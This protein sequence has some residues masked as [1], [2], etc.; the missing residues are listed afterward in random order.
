MRAFLRSEDFRG[1]L[2]IL[3][4]PVL[5]HGYSQALDEVQRLGLPGFDLSKFPSYNPLAVE[6]L[7]RL[8]EG[9]THGRRLADLVA[10]PLLPVTTPESEQEEE[11]GEN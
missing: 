3:N 4:T 9:Y 2:A 5:H 1:D 11:E 7:D 6:Q 10:D 8:V